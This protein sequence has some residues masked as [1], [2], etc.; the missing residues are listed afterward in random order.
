MAFTIVIR[1]VDHRGCGNDAAH[2]RRVREADILIV[3]GYTN[4][5]P[6]HWP[7]WQSKLSTARG[8]RA[9]VETVR[10]N[11]RRTAKA[12]NGPAAG[13]HRRT[14]ARRRDSNQAMPVPAPGRRRLLR[15]ASRVANQDKP[16]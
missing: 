7:R 14:F 2:A 8:S 3:P 6:D 16:I 5:G 4:S 10:E 11:G 12:V 13:R 15:G 1:C 9:K